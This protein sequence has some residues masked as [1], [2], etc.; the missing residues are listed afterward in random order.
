MSLR[1][2]RRV[3]RS[4]NFGE[5][6]LI[7][8][9]DSSCGE[10]VD[11]FP[12]SWGRSRSL[13]FTLH[14]GLVLVLVFWRPH[15]FKAWISSNLGFWGVRAGSCS[16]RCQ[17]SMPESFP[18]TLYFLRWSLLGRGAHHFGHT[19]LIRHT[20]SACAALFWG[21]SAMPGFFYMCWGPKPRSR[22][23]QQQVPYPP[24]HLPSLLS[25]RFKCFIYMSRIL[26]ITDLT[27]GFWFAFLNTDFVYI[28]WPLSRLVT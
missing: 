26:I 11:W 10:C 19:E 6:W 23:L 5:F 2:F 12:S 24:S 1:R 21:Y 4:L 3:W 17:S 20:G 25:S 15:G 7:L 27:S 13:F 28:L 8:R 18:L 9:I 16:H 14:R 22:S